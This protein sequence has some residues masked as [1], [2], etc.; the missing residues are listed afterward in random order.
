MISRQGDNRG[1][2]V[3]AWIGWALGAFALLVLL[4]SA[5]LVTRRE[6]GRS[7]VRLDDDQ[8]RIEHR[9]RRE[10]IERR[11]VDADEMLREGALQDAREAYRRVEQTLVEEL[12][13]QPDLAELL[14]RAQEGHDATIDR[15]MDDMMRMREELV[16]PYT[17]PPVPPVVRV[18]PATIPA[19]P[20]AVANGPIPRQ[21]QPPP[22]AQIIGDDEI[23]MAILKG[24]EYL[25]TRLEKGHLDVEEDQQ[26]SSLR[27]GMEALATYALLQAGQAIKDPRLSPNSPFMSKLLVNMRE[28]PRGQSMTYTRALRVLALSMVNRPENR[29]YIK[30]DV[31]W[32]LRA[33]KQGA[34]TYGIRPAGGAFDNS[35]SQYG[36]LGVWAGAEAGV[37][38][39]V[40][41][42]YW[43][44]V[45]KHWTDTQLVDGQWGYSRGPMRAGYAMTC[46][47][48]ASLFVTHDHLE[49]MQSGRELGKSP[50]GPA[51]TKGL[52]WLEKD[53]NSVTLDA[54]GVMWM[55]GYN[56]YGLERVGL[57]SGFKHFGNHDWY[58]ELSRKVVD[59]QNGD[60]SWSGRAG[61]AGADPAIQ[62]AYC[63]L[64]LCRG[65]H[66][67]LMNKL[68]FDGSWANRPRDVANLAHYATDRLERPINWQ[69]IH[70]NRD[71]QEWTDSPILYVASHQPVNLKDAD[72]DKIRSFIAAGGLL[73]TQAD[74]SS[75]AFNSFAEDLARRLFPMYRM[76]DLPAD[77]QIYSVLFP[78]KDGPRLRTVSNGSRLL[79]LHSPTDIALDWQQR[80]DKTKETTFQTGLNIFLYAAGK[81]DLRNR[82]TSPVVRPPN[83][84]VLHTVKVAR[85]M[86]DGNW[87]PEPAAI[88]RLSNL[89]QLSTGWRI[90]PANVA[91]ADLRPGVSPL[92]HLTGTAGQTFSAAQMGAIKKYVEGGGVLVVDACGGSEGF[93]RSINE[94]LAKTFGPDAFG[95]MPGDHPAL[96]GKGPGMEDPG[97]MRLRP[98]AMTKNVGGGSL[99]YLSAGKGCVI[100]SYLDMTSTL[101]GTNA[102]DIVGYQSKWAEAFMKNLVVW[103]EDR[104]P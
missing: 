95:P 50:Y 4:F 37:G 84:P 64:F 16:R 73:F 83:T 53:D 91:I 36:L 40:P 90:E 65:R 88:G 21:P 57:A 8:Q 97:P 59:E 103:S 69:V 42:G 81:S 38:V 89:L 93:D 51:L 94:A 26:A 19:P 31:E 39:E 54:G 47:G 15:I 86:Y 45:E 75:E 74:A 44:M 10:R 1:E 72:V 35:N 85:L 61:F 71:W 80:K 49:A 34:Y 24:V 56:L 100:V 2:L 63:L 14:Q 66:P 28:M 25:A 79:M 101:L 67:I 98:Y 5:I 99:R 46:A 70:L 78:V 30:A 76:E 20:I 12:P 11:L 29:A 23:G 60:G 13:K 7:V 32:L 48:V 96:R 27:W 82:L 18:P 68:R 104:H 58:R 33:Q 17:P 77:H 41:Q 62:S 9:E 102:W 55:T 52:A 22:P 43:R 92:A 87:D 3:P 6:A